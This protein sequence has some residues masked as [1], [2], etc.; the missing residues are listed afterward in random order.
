M[1]T[2][3]VSVIGSVAATVLTFL[4]SLFWSHRFRWW[5][6]R[7]VA[8]LSDGDF[9]QTWR[10]KKESETD[11]QHEISRAKF[12]HLISGRGSELQRSTF[13]ALLLGKSRSRKFQILLP[14]VGDADTG[15]WT[16]KRDQELSLFDPSFGGG[17]LAQQI[18]TT[19]SSLSS[20]VDAGFVELRR[21]SLPHIGR[22][23]ITDRVAFFTPYSEDRHGRDNPVMKYPAGSPL[24]EIL[25]RFFEQSWEAE[26][27]PT[28]PGV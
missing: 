25:E 24:Y 23:V 13:A 10:N 27:L 3:I 14:A 19:V 11:L 8:R 21:F 2:F 7:T 1:S 15:K 5:L 22:I 12:V 26:D 6:S 9:G 18:E 16:E 20:A 4:G 28:R 17:L